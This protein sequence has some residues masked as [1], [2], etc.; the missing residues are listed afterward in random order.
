MLSG[1]RP[2]S[3][4]LTW[5]VTPSM[6]KSS[7]LPRWQAAN[8]RSAQL[9]HSHSTLHKGTASRSCW[10]RVL[11]AVDDQAGSKLH[12][13]PSPAPVARCWCCS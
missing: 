10:R 7:N 9:V 13:L 5:Q 1:A 4:L 8:M 12:A 3:A 11:L 6:Q 2:K